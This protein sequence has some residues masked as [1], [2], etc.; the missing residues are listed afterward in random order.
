MLLTGYQSLRQQ[1]LKYKNEHVSEK[2]WEIVFLSAPYVLSLG[3]G[4]G[5]DSFSESLWAHQELF[6]C[7][8]WCCGPHGCKPCWLSELGELG[9]TLLEFLVVEVLDVG[10]KSFT[11]QGESGCWEGCSLCFSLSYPFFSGCFLF[12]QWI[13]TSPLV[14]WFLSEETAPRV[15]VDLE[16]LW[17]EVRSGAPLYHYL[18]NQ[19]LKIYEHRRKKFCKIF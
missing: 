13:W 4:I 6:L 1:L 7:L 10:F 11:P 3:V 2:D 8:L 12:T 16:C 15:A 18:G 9:P 17:E 5:V 14:S 19:T